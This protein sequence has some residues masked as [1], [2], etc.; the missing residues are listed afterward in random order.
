MIEAVATNKGTKPV[1][2]FRKFIHRLSEQKYLQAMVIPGIIW[3]FIFCYMPMYG[4]SVAFKDYN[5]V[6]P[7]SQAPWVGLTHFIEFV[8]DERFVSVIQNTL[9]ISILKLAIGFPLAIIFALLLNELT[10]VKFK[11]L[12]QTISYLPHFLSWVVLGGLMLSW[13][14]DSGMITTLLV[15]LKIL[16]E[17]ISFLAEPRYF[18]GLMVTSEVWKELGWS[19]IIYLAAIAGIDQQLYEAARVDGASRLRQAWSV[20]LPCIRGTIVILF[21]LA[22]STVLNSNFDQ[23]FVLKNSLNRQTSD[24]A[25]IYVYRMGIETARFSFATAVGLLKSIVALFLLLTANFTTKKLT[26]SSLF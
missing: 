6:K 25:D 20:T 12:V 4:I 14:S 21:I 24:V 8:T 19:A 2:P 3:M 10:S 15:Q 9:G 26:G 13:L 17:P 18:W 7:M 5:I 23:I 22:I 11:R 16:K 1:T